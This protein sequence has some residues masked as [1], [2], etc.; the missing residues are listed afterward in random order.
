MIIEV[1]VLY[2][3]LSNLNKVK[4]DNSSIHGQTFFFTK[5]RDNTLHIGVSDASIFAL[6]D[7]GK[8]VPNDFE[9]FNVQKEP[10]YKMLSKLKKHKGLC[11][12]YYSAADSRMYLTHEKVEFESSGSLVSDVCIAN[13]EYYEKS[14]EEEDSFTVVIP[15]A[16]NTLTRFFAHKS[17]EPRRA[18]IYGMCIT[19]KDD[20]TVSL[21][22]TDGHRLTLS[23]V[24]GSVPEQFVIS[25]EMVQTLKDFSSKDDMELKFK[26]L[27]GG[28]VSVETG[29][30]TFM[31][32]RVL[33]NYPQ[34]A[35]V[36]PKSFPFVLKTDRDKV[37]E[38]LEMLKSVVN[39]KTNVVQLHLKEGDLYFLAR[40][41]DSEAKSVV[42][43]NVSNQD[44]PQLIAL[45][46]KYV[47]DSL[48]TLTS[49]EVL[50][51]LQ[52]TEMA[53]V[54]FC[55]DEDDCI[56]VVMPMRL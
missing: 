48:K 46:V 8:K 39:K 26:L 38:S 25:H 6:C 47:L 18:N 27:E 4:L 23:S 31:S 17:K 34:I 29:A 36:L 51:K 50:I 45:N 21:C 19:P 24:K 42:C 5:S 1:T 7:T 52:D 12:F 56:N 16:K 54:M 33:E 44:L 13:A 40:N 35:E 30:Y 2:D 22:T 14:V 15:D 9:P 3:I 55:T 10:L 28:F 53:P 49:S 43:E 41:A 11:D 37:I 20:N 32:Y